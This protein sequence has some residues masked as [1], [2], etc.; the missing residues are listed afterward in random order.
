[1]PKVHLH[2]SSTLVRQAPNKFRVC[3]IE[4][5]PG[6]SADYER[7]F[8]V[9]SNGA[10]LGGILSFPNHPADYD[11]PDQRNPLTAI[12]FIGDEVTVEEHNGK[13]GFWADYNVAKSRPDV[14]AFLEEFHSKVGLSIF[15]EGS[16]REEGGRRLAEAFADV[17]EYRSVDIVVAPG[18]RGKFD[19]LAESLRRITEASTPVEE[20]EVNVDKIEEALGK[21]VESQTKTA[22]FIES[23]APVLEKLVPQA[24]ANPETPSAEEIEKS[25][26]DRISKFDE[27]VALIA[28]A[29]LTPSQ[30][31]ELREIAKKGD[32]VA[33][34]VESAKKIKSELVTQLAESAGGRGEG[35]L[36]GGTAA[37]TYDP[38]VPGF[39]E[40]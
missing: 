40:V 9:E 23:L 4:E 38:R 13:L 19:R 18:A 8:F 24:P 37:V 15:S 20:E 5:G 36:G 33:P 12:G 14:A 6:N 28:G 11:R 10:K 2:E 17:D 22:Q 21:L 39:G 25:I 1:M 30:A 3:L 35:Y 7:D 32:D 31:A 34:L 26:E 27:A 29:D 16:V